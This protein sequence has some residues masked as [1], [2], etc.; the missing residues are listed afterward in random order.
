[1][2]SVKKINYC[3]GM[4]NGTNKRFLSKGFPEVFVINHNGIVV[5]QGHP[6]DA[7]FQEAIVRA[8]ENAPPP[9]L[10]SVYLGPF[11]DFRRD[12]SG[13]KFFA[14]AYQQLMAKA[15]DVNSPDSELA[16]EIIEEI[17]RR[18]NK[19][20]EEANNLQTADPAS[21]LEFYQRI[22]K[23]YAGATATASAQAAYDKL[24][25]DPN[26]NENNSN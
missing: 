11:E 18:I 3:V 7:K 22:L 21:A 14:K 17:E 15:E 5:W 19:K 20:I 2:I 13:G 25:N 9:F 4:D 26:A 6:A 12:L 1:M 10:D 24:K 8:L 16:S 23:N